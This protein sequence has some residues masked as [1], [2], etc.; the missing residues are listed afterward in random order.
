MSLILTR[1]LSIWLLFY[2]YG[3]LSGTVV[4]SECYLYKVNENKKC[5]ALWNSTDV[6]GGG[7]VFSSTLID[8]VAFV[9]QK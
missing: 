7:L 8:N 3:F 9:L 4:N 2:L 5:I 1:S 6:V